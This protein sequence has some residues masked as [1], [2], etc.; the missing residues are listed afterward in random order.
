MRTTLG[1]HA[2]TYAAYLLLAVVATFPLAFQV[3]DVIVGFEYG[4]GREMAHH[5]WWFGEALRT[6]QNP[7]FMANLAYPVGIDAITLWA[8]PLQFF[9]AWA[10]ALILPVPA[11]A[12]VTLLGVM[13]L[14]G[15]S[16][17]YMM[18]KRFNAERAEKKTIEKSQ[19]FSLRSSASNLAAFLS[20]VV[21]MLFPTMMGHLGAG[22]AGLLVQF[23]VPLY[24]LALQNLTPRPALQVARGR[25][26]PIL[27]AALWFVVSGWGH[28]LQILYVTL[29][30]TAILMLPPL[31]RRDWRAVGRMLIAA[32]IGAAALIVYLLP[33]FAGVFGAGATYADA[34]GGVR[35]S[36]D[37]LAAVSPSFFHPL[38][39]QILDYPRR[40]LGVNLDEGAAYVGVAAG[41]LAL[42][43]VVRVKQARLWLVFALVAYG[44]SLGALLKVFDQ[45]VALEIDGY[46]TYI[47]LPFALVAE[48]PGVNLM[49][50][51]GRFNFGLALAV[52]VLAG[53][54]MQTIFSAQRRRETPKGARNENVSLR[55]S[56]SLRFSLVFA[57]IL[58]ILFDY[59]TFAPLPT[60]PAALPVALH[61]LAARTDVRAVFGIPWDNL[62]AAKADL[63]YHTAHR[64]ALIAGQVTRRTTVDPA[65]LT[66]LQTTLDPALLDAAGAD[67]VI[68]HRAFDDGT[69]FA[70]ASDTLGAPFYA[71]AQIALFDVP[72]SSAARPFAA[73]VPE[74][75]T[76]TDRGD[77][78]VYAQR[79]GWAALSAQMTGARPLTLSLDGT[80]IQTI[81]PS[82]APISV[83]IALDAGYQTLSLAFDP[84]CPRIIPAVTLTCAGVTLTETAIIY[85]D[86]ADFPSARDAQFGRGVTLARWRLNQADDTLAVWLDWRF[87]E[88]L[89][90]DAIRFV[91]IVS[92][93]GDVIA[94]SDMPL[95][96]IAAGTRRVEAVTL[97]LPADLP[98]GCCTVYGGWY[99]Y[100]DIVR[101]PLVS[102]PD[103][104]N[105]RIADNLLL[106][107]AI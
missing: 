29:P 15:W 65:L 100:P 30:L 33:T 40:V 20:G 35:Y 97:A 76:I 66:I 98:L 94:Q 107:G 14:N 36:A 61:D 16:V 85:S 62:I 90:T 46:L 106:L 73:V 74:T 5:L 77:I 8:N 10:L 67:I 22:H 70:R 75:L 43:G 53:Y 39:G 63:Y 83:P 93:A 18:Q 56:A 88:A 59:Q 25:I 95:G 71:D 103:G 60:T 31:L 47:T 4:D 99:T 27:I 37:L 2:A 38:W 32:M 6:G 11:A 57:L 19:T 50:A 86:D 104:A 84:P 102:A 9:P 58:L 45:P 101:F 3:G 87:A 23:P 96:D 105:E 44:L 17:F 68:V 89:T 21:F 69:L 13:A 1:R 26:R 79:P 52:A 24:A 41:V 51:P 81:T 42:I 80:P 78:Y 7:F 49:R 48:L 55:P 91:Q 82:A 12:N 28:T 72:A 64:H 54:G 34:G 92:D